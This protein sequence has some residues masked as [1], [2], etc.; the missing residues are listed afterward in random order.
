MKRF[1]LLAVLMLLT[2]MPLV[3]SGCASTELTGTVYFSLEDAPVEG[4]TIRVD[5]TEAISDAYGQFALGNM[6]LRVIEGQVI[7]EGF[8]D[9]DFS[10]NLEE[11]DI[12][13]HFS[14]EIPASRTTIN[15]IENSYEEAEVSTDDINIQFSGEEVDHRLLTSGFQTGIVALGT[16]DLGITSEIYES[17]EKEILLEEGEHEIKVVLDLTL[18]ETY[19]RF[20]RVNDLHRHAESYTY[21]H[22]DIQ[23]L[24]SAAEWAGAHSTEVSI[25]DA[26]PSDETEHADWISELTGQSYPVVIAF[27][28]P[29]IAE[30]RGN[31]VAF[32]ETQYWTN[33]DGR[34]Y[35]VFPRKFW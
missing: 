26:A 1:R 23:A 25:I 28:R 31:R 8:P 5:D 12:E 22:P 24:V 4:A 10:V 6:P 29:Y 32:E 35:R 13:H 21:L 9:F 27:D 17:L 7:I 19:R 16:Y 34:W 3:F 20:N 30:A 2:L 33:L 15:F 18:D 11:A 14:I